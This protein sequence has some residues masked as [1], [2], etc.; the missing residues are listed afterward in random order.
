MSMCRLFAYLS[1][2]ERSPYGDLFESKYSILRQSEVE[3]H[4]DGWG[5]FSFSG[6]KLNLLVRCTAPLTASVEVAKALSRSMHSKC[7]GFF[8]RKASNP[9]GLDR[10]RLI[11]IDATQPFT[12]QNIVFMHNGSINAPD[13]IMKEL[14]DPPMQ[15]RSYNDS[16]VY[17]IIFI[18]YLNELND[19][20]KA[21]SE[22]VK[23]ITETYEK[24]KEDLPM[25]QSMHIRL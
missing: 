22:T 15:P 12:Y 17:F 4:E 20:Y 21:F 10:G 5:M 16:E 13:K 18:K 3:G 2:Q 6:E 25:L 23:F 14:Q 9:L 8:V 11:T 24:V 19:V 1:V 7:A